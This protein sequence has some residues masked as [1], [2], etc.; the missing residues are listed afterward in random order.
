[1]AVN[2]SVGSSRTNKK[3]YKRPKVVSLFSGAGG[4]DLGFTEEG[5]SIIWANDI[6]QNAVETYREN[7]GSHIHLGDVST[8]DVSQIPDCD[9]LI[10]GFPC[11]G[12]SHA[13]IHRSKDDERNQLYKQYLR[14][15]AAKRPR[16]FVAEN[17][18]GIL[19]MEGGDAIKRIVSDFKVAG[20]NVEYRLLNAANYGVPQ[21]RERVFIVG[22]R[23]DIDATFVFPKPT[24]DK[25]GSNGLPTWTSV[26]DAICNIPDPDGP[27]ANTVPN[28]TYS[29][30]K[31]VMN[32]Y[33]GK[34]P[35][36]P[37]GPAPTVTARG[38]RKGGVVVLPNPLSNRRMTVREL[39]TIQDFPINYHFC[40]TQ[41]DCYRQIGNAVPVGLARAIASS[42]LKTLRSN[43]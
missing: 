28:N 43:A 35:I 4:L 15:L 9:V 39:A 24:C 29:K 11:Q 10:G 42:L 27:Q 20:Y 30:Y 7:L 2:H 1:M 26:R 3:Q 18:K 21:K 32:G 12:F 37:D 8:M 14:V 17:V 36:D 6:D 19:T 33:L 16:A 31:L 34:R 5:Y 23:K 41:T 13:N 38:D 22:I 40:G 25:N